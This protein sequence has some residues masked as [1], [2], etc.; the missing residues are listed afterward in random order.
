[1]MID[2]IRLFFSASKVSTIPIERSLF[3][4]FYLLFLLISKQAANI[5]IN[6]VNLKALIK[7]VGHYS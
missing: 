1:M 3:T 5:S 4:N 6:F 7:I 2:L